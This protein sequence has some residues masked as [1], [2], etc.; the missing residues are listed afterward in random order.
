[1][2]AFSDYLEDI[3]QNHLLR[4]QAFTPPTQLY[5]ALFTS[6]TSDAGGGTEA[7]GGSYV[8]QPFSLDAASG[9]SASNAASIQFVN[10]PAATFTHAAVID[11]VSGGN[12]LLHGA[13]SSPRTVGAGQSVLLSAGDVTVDFTAGSSATTLFRN[14]MINRLLRNQ[15]HT[16]G[17]I[18][19]ALYTSA[20]DIAGGG[21][22]VTGGSYARQTVTF[23][24]SSGGFVD[25]SAE[26]VFTGMPDLT[27]GPT[28]ITHWALHNA[29]G[30]MLVQGALDSSATP[31]AGDAVRFA[32]NAF[33]YT[34]R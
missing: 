25:N 27:G 23:T 32:P 29:G 28:P 16:P 6:A 13:L 11:A 5:L 24:A 30:D 33:D 4:A 19:M 21:T 15:A 20:T 22:E 1:M 14:L 18:S 8:R 34:L 9:G 2:V 3:A 17:A 10:M 7:V 31:A 12:F 26:V